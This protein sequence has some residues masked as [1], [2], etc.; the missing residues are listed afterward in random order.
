MKMCYLQGFRYEQWVYCYLMHVDCIRLHFTKLT[1]RDVCLF[2]L[3]VFNCR[4]WGLTSS[5]LAVVSS[6]FSLIELAWIL[7]LLGLL[8]FFS[9]RGLVLIGFVL[10]GLVLVF[11]SLLIILRCLKLFLLLWRFILLL[12]LPNWVAMLLA[13]FR[14]WFK[15]FARSLDN[16]GIR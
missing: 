10:R 9:R 14:R 3:L 15:F 4:E 13:D 1:S 5:S 2:E 11:S 12:S 16:F 7:I 8:R 6:C